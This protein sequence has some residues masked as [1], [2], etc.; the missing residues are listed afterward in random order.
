M[1][2]YAD[3]ATAVYR[4]AIVENP[5]QPT[6]PEA[7]A[8]ELPGWVWIIWLLNLVLFLPLIL[9]IEYTIR[10]VYPVLAI[11]ENENP[12]AYEPVSLNDETASLAEDPQNGAPKPA[13]TNVHSGDF[14]VTSSLRGC[15]RTLRASGG[16]RANFRGFYC[17]AAQMVMTWMLMGIFGSALGSGASSLAT[18]LASLSLV[19]FSTAW[20]H[21]V[22][23]Q[24]SPVRFWRRLP[25][26]KRTFEATW[27]A[28]TLYWAAQ[29]ITRWIPL[30]TGMLLGI[31]FTNDGTE[32]SS[33]QPDGFGWKLLTMVGVAIIPA[34][35]LLI[36]AHII[37]VRVQA[38]L[39][40]EDTETI[41]PFDRSFE[42]TV[43]PAV[44]GGLGYVS[45]RDAWKTFSRSAWRRIVKL[46]IKIYAISF[47]FTIV[48]GIVIGVQIMFIL[49]NSSKVDN[50]GGQ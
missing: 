21:I 13:G 42:G 8:Y 3:I 32:Q 25:P 4:R 47:A 48:A 9:I 50:G 24:P 35:V 29:E 16:F 43:E 5:S 19:Q 14:T 44:V 7:P 22:I 26:F 40:P 49:A 27:R 46:Y 31:Q 15:H 18:L 12:P 33:E 17:L 10:Q 20:V 36:P 2:H 23:S 45:M 38:S 39:L 37:L 34:I 11:V 6:S 1:H 41:L 28:V 30:F